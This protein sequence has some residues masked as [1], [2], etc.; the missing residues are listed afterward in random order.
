[1]R[2]LFPRFYPLRLP[3]EGVMFQSSRLH[4]V[5]G[6]FGVNVKLASQFG[7]PVQKQGFLG[8][9]L[10]Q[11]SIGPLRLASPTLNS[12]GPRGPGIT[13]CANPSTKGLN[14]GWPRRTDDLHELD[15]I[16]FRA[17]RGA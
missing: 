13:T 10:P 5:D 3:S 17:G 14:V 6:D 9:F 4:K 7:S 16:Y 2:D 8:F 11:E 15:Q 12:P 1:M